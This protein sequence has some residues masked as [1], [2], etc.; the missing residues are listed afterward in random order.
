MVINE[1]I[2]MD[3]K[4]DVEKNPPRR[5]RFR[6]LKIA[7]GTIAGIWVL[8]LVV[9][10]I[11]LN[12]AF[13]M[14]MADRYIPQY[15]DADVHIGK[16][17]ASVFKS[18]PNLNLEV[19]D[20]V[21]TYPHDRYAQFDSLG[22]DGILR[23]AGR[24]EGADTLAAIRKTS[25]SVNYLSAIF[26]KIRIH[27]ASMDKPHVF[28]HYFGDGQANWNVL[29]TS[30]ASGESAAEDTSA[31]S[32]PVITVNNVCLTGSPKIVYTDCRDT[33]FA[34]ILLKQMYFHGKL[35]T[36]SASASRLGLEVDS[37]FV[38]GRLPADTLA[39]AMEHLDI[40]EKNK[41]IAFDAG[42]KAFLGMSEYGRVIVPLGLKGHVSVNDTQVPEVVL[43][44]FKADVATISMTGKGEARFLADSTYLKAEA[45]VDDCSVEDIIQYFGKNFL[46]EA[47]NLK[48][49]AKISLTSLCDGY[50]NPARGTLPELIAELV[51]P[52]A[53]VKYPGIPDGSVAADINASTDNAG[54][55][56]ISIDDMCLDFGGLDFDLTGTVSDVAGED[57]M[58][59]VEGLAYASL[60]EMMAFLPDSCGYR[61]SG[62]LDALLTGK[63]RL[64]QM[65]PYNF[66]KAGLDGYIRSHSV[67]LVS[68]ADSLYAW[69]GSPEIGV[70]TIAN[71]VDGSMPKGTKV[72]ALTA[73]VDS[74]YATYGSDMTVR[75]SGVHAAAQNAAKIECKEHGSE[76]HPI[77][78]SLELGKV[79][80]SGADSLFAG[81][82][83]SE[84]TFTFSQQEKG[85]M[86]E[87]R[88]SLSSSSSRIFARE[89]VNRYGFKDAKFNASARM[90]AFENNQRRKMFLD[91]LQRVYPGTPRDSLFHRMIRAK[92]AG[93]P[94]PDFIAE[95]DFRKRD[96]D[97]TLNESLAKY[98]KEWDMKGGL[99]IHSG[100]V[101]TPYFPLKNVVED[102]RGSFSNDAVHL[103]NFTFR[104]GNSDLSANG[105]LSGLRKALLGYGP[106]TLDLKLTSKKIDANELLTAYSAGVKFSPET[107]VN[108]ADLDDA[109][110]LATVS[111]SQEDARDSSYAL[112]VV[113]ANL[114]ANISLQANEVDYSDLKISW[115]A[116]DMTMKERCIQLTNTLA[117]SN[118]GDI[119]FEGFYST[120]TKTDIKAGFDLNLSDITADKVV[121]LF[122][123]VDTIMPMLTSFK[124]ML[125]CEMAATTD[126][127]TNMNFVTP[128]MSGIM[129]ISGRDVV[130]EESA[131]FKK[132]ARM[133]MFKN[134][135]SG[136]MADMSVSGLISNNRLEI[137][138]FVLKIDRY[139]LAMSGMQNF[140]QTFK[141]HVSVLKSPIPFRFGINIFG[142]FDNWKYRIG[143]AQYKSTNVP[144][145]TAQIDTLQMNLVSSIHNIFTKGVDLA[146]KQNESMKD[147]IDASKKSMGFNP[148]AQL[149]SLDGSKMKMLDSLQTAY[150]N[151]VDSVLNARMDSLVVITEAAPEA[152]ESAS[153]MQQFID[154]QVQSRS[155]REERQAE[156]RRKREERQTTRRGD[157]TASG[158]AED[159]ETL[160]T[161]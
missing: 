132:L 98:L 114:N 104:P 131:A 107:L 102:V 147:A 91:S 137:F 24:A 156:R 73:K 70:R 22:V 8:L 57:P 4:G 146:V 97:I 61:A 20:L 116:A 122:P 41:V 79:F 19:T 17:S 15:I 87:P 127:D 96:L 48:T 45:S 10:Q 69:L 115:L 33:V 120:R 109:E 50:Y 151:P 14:K 43:H 124:G 155:S 42:A 32:L 108:D 153:K 13:L 93:R 140:D 144:V 31:L 152:G 92:M 141:Y 118:M 149:D 111:A 88:L 26:G 12:S 76:H 117:T 68:E 158:D 46:P 126:L 72:M 86:M 38:S 5:K 56:D 74:L 95:K 29:K 52:K 159:R 139:T 2:D 16:I 80:L 65:D 3:K 85:R 105:V 112:I 154:S 160:G 18:F 34:A 150:D 129:K 84:N 62:E 145:F 106:M 130:L 161:K 110:Y 78:G 133:L 77:V 49:D 94:V 63:I 37:L 123:A 59:D 71:K 47:M 58:F 134:K 99:D 67:A 75:G 11:A 44:D 36:A 148:D 60:D 103:D 100:I 121:Q 157:V 64:S 83:G 136:K 6:G 53:D 113:P 143:K 54:R 55:L 27:E 40:R 128:S 28:A 101:I 23:H 30:G 138:P 25:L 66:Y 35:T 125:D 90:T 81:V 89:G 39:V 135:K 51:L 7:A 82:I 9:I 142:N 1:F 21:V 119:F